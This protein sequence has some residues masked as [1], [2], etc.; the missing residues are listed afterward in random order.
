[1]EKAAKL[2]QNYI[3]EAA[4]Y[5]IPLKEITIRLKPWWNSKLTNLRKSLNKFKRIFKFN[6]LEF[7]WN[8]F[9]IARNSYFNEIRKSKIKNWVNFLGNIKGKEI[10]Q[11]YKYTKLNII[12]KLPPIKSENGLVL[13]FPAKCNA[14]I[15]VI[16]PKTPKI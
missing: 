6:W 2:I 5:A 3:L 16:Y 15:N 8:Q 13:N 11:A 12:E 1:M 7:N 4:K 10:F 14:F 9:K